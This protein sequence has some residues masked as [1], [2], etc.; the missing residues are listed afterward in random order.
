MHARDGKIADAAGISAI[1]A[2]SCTTLALS[3]SYSSTT[4]SD[5]SSS[6]TMCLSS[7]YCTTAVDSAPRRPVYVPLPPPIVVYDPPLPVIVYVPP[8]LPADQGI[9]INLDTGGQQYLARGTFVKIG[10]ALAIYL[11]YGAQLHAF[12][13]WPQFLSAGGLSD[14]SNVV[15]FS[16]IRGAGLFGTPV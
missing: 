13:T 11:V 15:R 16:S 7:S 10:D 6:T 1:P 4:C 8:P 5:G 14:L 9:T 3:S 2:Q 12:S